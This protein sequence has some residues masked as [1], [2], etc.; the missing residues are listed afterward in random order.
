MYVV[1]TMPVMDMTDGPIDG[2]VVPLATGPLTSRIA[3]ANLA[4]IDAWQAL[5]DGMLADERASIELQAFVDAL[6]NGPQLAFEPDPRFI[7]T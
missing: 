6:T 2:Y 4:R 3:H 5:W 7:E 1:Y